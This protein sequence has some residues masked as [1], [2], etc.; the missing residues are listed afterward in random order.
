MDVFNQAINLGLGAFYLTKEKI[1]NLIDEMV[2]QGEI[3]HEQAKDAIEAIMK[4]S[5]EQAAYIKEL[6]ETQFNQ[7]YR[8]SVKISPEEYQRILKRLATLEEQMAKIA[9]KNPDAN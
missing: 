8:K 2:T 5:S 1:E 6:V 4:K 3:N 9:N 7:F